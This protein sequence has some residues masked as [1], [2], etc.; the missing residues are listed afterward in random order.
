MTYSHQTNC[1]VFTCGSTIIYLYI[2]VAIFAYDLMVN[3]NINIK[4]LEGVHYS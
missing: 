3:C 1:T 2:Y 4:N